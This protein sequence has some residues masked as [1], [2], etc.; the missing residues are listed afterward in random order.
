MVTTVMKTPARSTHGITRE[1]FSNNFKTIHEFFYFFTSAR[2][3]C[4]NQKIY[5]VVLFQSNVPVSNKVL[6]QSVLNK[7]Y[8][9][10]LYYWNKKI[11]NNFLYLLL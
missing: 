5:L 9:R 8:I 1:G 11:L 6:N 3:G 7:N 4:V 10:Q 2:L